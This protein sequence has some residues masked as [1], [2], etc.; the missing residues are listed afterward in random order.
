MMVLPMSTAVS[1]LDGSVMAGFGLGFLVVDGF[2]AS[3]N[4][5]RVLT[6]CLSVFQ[7]GFQLLE[8]V[9]VLSV[10]VWDDFGKK[11]ERRA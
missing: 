11:Q 10:D 7:L 2:D 5:C 4:L 6:V 9:A 3:T 8:G 1:D